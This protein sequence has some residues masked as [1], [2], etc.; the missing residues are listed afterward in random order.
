[1]PKFQACKVSLLFGVSISLSYQNS[2]LPADFDLIRRDRFAKW[3]AA[4]HYF[5]V[6]GGKN[7]Y[8]SQQISIFSI[9]S[10]R[11]GA[12]GMSFRALG[13]FWLDTEISAAVANLK[14]AG[15]L[16]KIDKF[17]RIN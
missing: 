2:Y 15:M 10:R 8:D 14:D 6:Y 1:M 17:T 12:F 16:Q 7:R 13:T 11:R 4:G 3:G 5:F 9:L